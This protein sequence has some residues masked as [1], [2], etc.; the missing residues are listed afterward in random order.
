M[1]LALMAVFPLLICA[2]AGLIREQPR[3]ARPP[4][5]DAPAEAEAGRGTPPLDE[6]GAALLSG[7]APER[8]AAQGGADAAARGAGPHLG[9]QLR[10][11]VAALATPAI[12]L[13]ALFL[14]AYSVRAHVLRTELGVFWLKG[15]S[16]PVPR[17]QTDWGRLPRAGV[18]VHGRNHVRA[19]AVC[20]FCWWFI[21]RASA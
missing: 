12:Y 17:L 20:C 10:A 5:P 13:P 18:P 4:T 14:F 16:I 15:A 1:V 11:L 3:R 2:T 6:E 19:R 8:A 7:D 21:Q 9:A